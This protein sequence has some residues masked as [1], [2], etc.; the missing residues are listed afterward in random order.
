LGVRD[1][2]DHGLRPTLGKSS[3]VQPIKARL[4]GMPYHLSYV[5]NVNRRIAVQAG[6]DANK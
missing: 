3:Q 6:S 1:K 2:E 5:E 4:G